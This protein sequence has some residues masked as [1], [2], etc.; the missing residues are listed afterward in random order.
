M[1]AKLLKIIIILVVISSF[2][3]CSHLKNRWTLTTDDTKLTIGINDS[4]ELYISELTNPKTGWNW[5][6][7]PS[8]FPLHPI[9]SRITIQRTQEI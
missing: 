8:V 2:I 3:S 6:E 1:K 5:T 9:I 4:S 7:K